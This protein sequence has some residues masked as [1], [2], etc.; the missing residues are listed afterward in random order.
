M[1]IYINKETSRGKLYKICILY[2]LE[3]SPM[4]EKYM[5]ELDESIDVTSIENITSGLNLKI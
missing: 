5:S 2:G 3:L 4:L 1:Y